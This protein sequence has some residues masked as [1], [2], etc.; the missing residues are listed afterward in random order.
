LAPMTNPEVDL[1]LTTSISTTNMHLNNAKNQLKKYK[2]VEDIIDEYAEVRL[3]MY[4]T[5][6][7]HLLQAI[8]AKL[9]EITNRVRYIR[10]VLD[11][12]IDLRHKSSDTITTLLQS[13]K[14]EKMND[15]YHYLI[16]MAMDSVSTE[17][18]THLE[19]EL[20]KLTEEKRILSAMSEKQMWLNELD[21]LMKVI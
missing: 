7:Q 16:K 9:N 8:H 18:V 11:G 15:T 17:N 13:L 1:K 10:F 19:G 6:K 2:T 14:L 4:L 20:A 12:T 5:R 3:Q 21:D